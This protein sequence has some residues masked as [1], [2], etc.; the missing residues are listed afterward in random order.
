[1]VGLGEWLKDAVELIAGNALARVAH[2]Q[3]YPVVLVGG[4]RDKDAAVAWGELDGVA[5]QAMHNLAD[6]FVGENHVQ[7]GDRA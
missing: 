3:A 5:N 4:Q 1:M 6:V 2:H 7:G